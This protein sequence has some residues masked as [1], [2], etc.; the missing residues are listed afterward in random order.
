[1]T[2]HKNPITLGKDFNYFE[3]IDVTSESF[4]T[5]C[6]AFV[7][8]KGAMRLNF[9][10]VSG[11][12]VEYSFNGNTLHGDMTAS[13]ATA[14]RDFGIRKGNKIWFRLASGGSAAV[15]RVEAWHIG[16]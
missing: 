3:N 13:T 7:Q 5:E 11:G 16:V 14:E 10:L 9:V 8:F 2:S 4:P 15:V 1:M 12:P 6:Q